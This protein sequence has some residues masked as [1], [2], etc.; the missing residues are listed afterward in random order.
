MKILW[1]VCFNNKYFSEFWRLKSS[2]KVLGRFRQIGCV[3]RT[4]FIVCCLPTVFTW[5]SS[6]NADMNVLHK[7]TGPLPTSGLP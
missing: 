4:Y 5:Q 3:M 6:V 7:D 1:T 2:I